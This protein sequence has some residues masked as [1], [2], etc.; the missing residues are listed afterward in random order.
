M[1]EQRERQVAYKTNINSLKSGNYVVQEGW[2]PNY[3]QVDNK[4]ISRANIIA[5]IVDKQA[6]ENLATVTLDDGSN[7]IVAKAF[8]EETKKLEKINVGDVVLLIGKPRKYNDELFISVE[9]IRKIDPL[10]AKVRKLE[11][12]REPKNDVQIPKRVESD[13]EKILNLV[14]SLDNSNGVEVSE[15]LKRTNIEGGEGIIDGLIKDGELYEN[16][17]GRLRSLI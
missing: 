5:A 13:R 14:R 3:I 6:T 16:R 11:L 7:I 8:N 17:P 9:I 2:D 1:A 10:W 12:N 15:V 4:N